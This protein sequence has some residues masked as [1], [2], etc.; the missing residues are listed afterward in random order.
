MT[1]LSS[2]FPLGLFVNENNTLDVS[3]LQGKVDFL[4]VKVNGTADWDKKFAQHVDEAN[5]LGIPCG[6][7]IYIDPSTVD[8]SWPLND[9]SRWG[10]DAVLGKYLNLK[11]TKLFHFVVLYY[12][13]SRMVETNG[14]AIDPQW[15]SQIPVYMADILQ[16]TFFTLTKN[17]N[18][19]NRQVA[20]GC[21]ETALALVNDPSTRWANWPFMSVV[22][23]L[24]S[25]VTWDNIHDEMGKIDAAAITPSPYRPLWNFDPYPVHNLPG[26]GNAGLVAYLGTKENFLKWCNYQASGTGTG[27]GSGTD[28]GTGSGTDT[29]GSGTTGTIDLSTLIPYLSRIAVAEEKQAT[30]LEKLSGVIK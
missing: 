14:N 6:L 10:K 17:T 24:S 1:Q 22:D 11:A 7:V 25:P 12:H 13:P 5:Q 16:D 19:Q 27:S 30:A 3:K 29:G 8:K 28:T 4:L 2:S 18:P 15:L 20:I 23:A 26:S 9:F 21:S